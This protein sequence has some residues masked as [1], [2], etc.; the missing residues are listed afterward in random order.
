LEH[1]FAR[2]KFS[3]RSYQGWILLNRVRLA[4]T[5]I[6]NDEQ[7]PLQAAIDTDKKWWEQ[8]PHGSSFV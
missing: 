8:I 7:F 3:L 4:G 5:C 2:K 1:W 6:Q